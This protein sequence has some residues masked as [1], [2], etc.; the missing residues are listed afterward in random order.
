MLL[1]H[2][3]KF[4]EISDVL[5]STIFGKCPGNWQKF[6]PPL[7]VKQLVGQVRKYKH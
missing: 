1:N 2:K 3:Y 4:Q 6:L 7:Q 5:G